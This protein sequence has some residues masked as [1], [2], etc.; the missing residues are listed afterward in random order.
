MPTS[1]PGLDWEDW[2]WIADSREY[3]R[4]I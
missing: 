1:V 4:K 2:Q 3:S